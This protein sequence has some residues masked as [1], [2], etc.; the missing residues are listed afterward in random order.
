MSGYN[1][2]HTN[3]ILLHHFDSLPAKLKSTIPRS[4]LSNWKKKNIS[5]FI[6]SDYISDSDL[7]TLRS[8]AKNRKLLNAAKALYYLFEVV[9]TLVKQADNKVALLRNNKSLILN[10]IEK[11]KPALGIKRILKSFGL[12]QAKFYYWL[13]QSKCRRS[14][15]QLCQKRHPN[16]LLPKEVK[17]IKQYLH[18]E[19][20]RNWSSLSVY[21]QAMRDEVVYMSIGT[22][23]KYAK[24]KIDY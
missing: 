22:W 7:S 1:S 9:S 19:R 16:Q 3:L 2:Y 20:F 5:G 23:Y 24:H 18:D 15:F 6:G 12:S 4:T 10:I 8:I 21:Y 17:L 13:E 14:I 11:V